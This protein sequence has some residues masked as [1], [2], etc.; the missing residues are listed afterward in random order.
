MSIHSARYVLLVAS[1]ALV[2]S[3]CSHST[4]PPTDGEPELIGTVASVRWSGR[5]TTV[6][7]TNLRTP[8]TSYYP[9]GVALDV[10]RAAIF[11]RGRDATF[12]RAT[13][14]DVV[15][16]AT[17]RA[18]STGV[19]LRSLPPQWEAVRVELTPASGA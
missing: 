9:R 19:E 1:V 10:G 4:A 11:V 14:A 15:V 8:D 17:I 12:R 2:A 3:A 18:W 5:P 7:I 6:L 16:G 13:S